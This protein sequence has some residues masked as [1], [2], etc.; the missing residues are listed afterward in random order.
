MT[1]LYLERGKDVVVEDERRPVL[2][3][4]RERPMYRR[5]GFRV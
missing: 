4:H 3:D 2:Y 1:T 5:V